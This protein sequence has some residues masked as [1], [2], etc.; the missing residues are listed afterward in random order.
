MSHWAGIWIDH[1]QAYIVFEGQAVE[2]I[3]SKLPARIRYYG[4]PLQADGS[5]DNQRDRQYQTHLNAYYDQLI[6]RLSSASSLYLMGPGKAKQEFKNRL[7]RH[8]PDPRIK[9]IETCDKLTPA[10]MAEKTQF[11][12]THSHPPR[13]QPPLSEGLGE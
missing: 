10:Q 2:R 5:A 1:K 13:R 4:R 6:A 9:K 7:N 3:A 8:Q 11:F 12:F